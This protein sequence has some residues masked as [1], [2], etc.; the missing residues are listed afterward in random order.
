MLLFFL[1]IFVYLRICCRNLCVACT[2][3]SGRFF[4]RFQLL[5]PSSMY[6]LLL[7]L[8]LFFC[9]IHIYVIV[10]RCCVRSLSFDYLSSFIFILPKTNTLISLRKNFSNFL[11]C[12]F[13]VVGGESYQFDSI[14]SMCIPFI[15]II[16][17]RIHTL[18]MRAIRHV[19]FLYISFLFSS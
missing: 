8:I 15:F 2:S 16:M 11:D 18:Y 3:I 7:L 9:H 13:G 10:C 17:H 14:C 12:I 1:L 4:F 5:L 6:P 19:I